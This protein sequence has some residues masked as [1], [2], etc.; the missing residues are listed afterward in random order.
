MTI[1]ITKNDFF[2]PEHRVN[3]E[4]FTRVPRED[5]DDEGRALVSAIRELGGFIAGSDILV[6][7]M[8]ADGKRQLHRRLFTVLSTSTVQKTGMDARGVDR[9]ILIDEYVFAP[10]G[11]WVSYAV[12]PE[13]PAV[14]KPEAPPEI[15]TPGEGTLKW[16]LGKQAY[17]V[18]V[19]GEVWTTVERIKGEKK[20]EYKARALSIAAGSL[21]KAA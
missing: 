16:N 12:T 19:A 8:S 20:D 7:V 11:D 18:I 15:Y 9:D 14:P 10:A 4:C 21:P 6:K 2:H 17:E 1:K 3:F 13:T 5:I